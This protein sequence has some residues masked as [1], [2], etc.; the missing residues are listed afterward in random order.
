MDE[1]L[2]LLHTSSIVFVGKFRDEVFDMFDERDLFDGQIDPGSRIRAGSIVQCAY[3]SGKYQFRA[4][5]DRID[6]LASDPEVVP[7]P[8]VEAARFVAEEID[9]V[10]KVAPVS[11]IGM[12]CDTIFSRRLISES[13]ARYCA[14]LTALQVKALVG[15]ESAST[16]VR[17]R[18]NVGSVEYDMRIEPH[19][20]SEGENLYVAVNAHRTV[21][22]AD[23][24]ESVLKHTSAFR[25]YVEDF[26]RRV[27]AHEI[28]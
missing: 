13:G 2:T 23:S 25:E 28:G 11:G 26:H 22:Q 7:E 9:V 12:N 14:S 15:V 21:N 1:E 5:P 27:I 17:T 4:V 16:M 8:L 6:V 20:Q 24:L 18:F 19:F 3:A 10:R